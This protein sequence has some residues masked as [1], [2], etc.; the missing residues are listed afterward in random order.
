MSP[1]KNC[2][3][4]G[5]LNGLRG[6]CLWEWQHHTRLQGSRA[7]TFPKPAF[8]SCA[9]DMF[10]LAHGRVAMLSGSSAMKRLYDELMAASTA[11]AW[12]T[13]T[14]G[15]TPTI[16]RV[17]SS[18]S[19]IPASLSGCRRKNNKIRTTR[20][21]EEHAARRRSQIAASIT[22]RSLLFGA[23][24][25]TWWRKTKPRKKRMTTVCEATYANLAHGDLWYSSCSQRADR[26]AVVHTQIG[27]HRWRV[28][29]IC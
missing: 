5:I 16:C 15:T 14:I 22:T 13:S 1:M 10:D 12:R 11:A 26:D 23:V 20:E 27:N 28:Q 4:K 21:N 7:G 29:R 19:P 24:S 6:V 18:C 2:I 8:I 3:V 9:R 17:A 25:R